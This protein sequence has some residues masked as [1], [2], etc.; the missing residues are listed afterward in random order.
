MSTA[1]AHIGLPVV[2]RGC[3][4]VSARESRVVTD[5]QLRTVHGSHVEQQDCKLHPGLEITTEKAADGGCLQLG[6]TQ[7]ATPFTCA[8]QKGMRTHA[9]ATCHAVKIALSIRNDRPV[10]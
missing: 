6:R 7:A 10:S 9:H 5:S 1:I 2:P 4:R 3:I 8:K